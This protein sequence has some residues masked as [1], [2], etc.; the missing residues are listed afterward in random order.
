MRRPGLA[1]WLLK[2]L[3][4]DDAVV[5]DLVEQYES[6]RSSQ[7][8]W[9]QVLMATV[10][11]SRPHG[12]LTL[13][14]LALGWAVLWVF[15][16]VLLPPLGELDGYVVAKGLAQ[17]YS[18]GWWLRG[19]VTWT[20]TG[21]P[22]L[23]S[24]W[25]VARLAWRTPLLPVLTFAVSVSTVI[26]IALILDTGPDEGFNLR[27]WLTVPLFLMVAPATGIALGGFVAARR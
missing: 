5:G 10:S 11:I 18:V 24:G 17:P 12:W 19:L 23:A 1:M 2:N 22:F 21:F 20:L 9:R 6:G 14:T 16:G 8:L 7:W 3:G 13:G 26:L 27:V 4:V 15:F 25:L